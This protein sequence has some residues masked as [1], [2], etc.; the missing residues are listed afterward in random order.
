MLCFRCFKQKIGAPSYLFFL[1]K[2]TFE[3]LWTLLYSVVKDW[4][5]KGF[6]RF[7]FLV[8]RNC[9]P[10]VWQT[11]RSWFEFWGF[12][13]LDINS[14][15]T[16]TQF[17]GIL[18]LCNLILLNCTR[19]ARYFLDGIDIQVLGHLIVWDDVWLQVLGDTSEAFG[20]EDFKF[21]LRCHISLLAFWY[22]ERALR[23]L[24][25]KIVILVGML[26]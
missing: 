5:H 22:I 21:P 14:R 2:F 24:L 1:I 19:K 13:L 11:R 8:V 16:Q 4:I 15:L 10:R 3:N 9:S 20:L 12:W 26:R 7:S 6:I 18:H 23:T 17:L 25:L